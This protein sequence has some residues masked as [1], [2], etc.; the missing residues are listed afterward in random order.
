MANLQELYYD[1]R[2]TGSL[3]GVQRLKKAADD[4][5]LTATTNDVKRFL[6][7]Q[8][9]YTLF[10]P[11][12][13]KF[14]RRRVLFRDAADL[15]QADL[16]DMTQLGQHNTHRYFL[17]VINAFTKKA[18]IALLK[19]KTAKE[20]AEAFRKMYY[21]NNL[22]YRNLQTDM[23]GE[24]RS[25]FTATLNDLGVNQ[26]FA[27]S[28]KKAALIERCIKTIKTRLWRWMHKNNTYI[29]TEAI[30]DIVFSYNHSY[31]RSIG[32][33]PVEVTEDNEEEV[34]EKLFPD[35]D[36]TQRRYRFNPGD[37]VRVS[38]LKTLLEK[39]YTPTTSYPTY[40]VV[41]RSVEAD[42][43]TY[44]LRDALN[45]QL[46][47]AFYEEELTRF[48]IPPNFQW[49]VERTIKSRRKYGRVEHLIKWVDF[50]P[51]YNSWV[52]AQDLFPLNR[53]R[54]AVLP[55]LDETDSESE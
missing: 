45:E 11:M 40:T 34:R 2:S 53:R 23:G 21:D 51:R 15:A 50:P 52:Q 25:E 46:K 17:L 4:A 24:F 54:L 6:E 49:R 31:H 19:R 41:D 44:T 47:G 13:K 1:P 48:N 33:K 39:G 36:V 29:W 32:M 16:G 26:Y 42:R 22:L 10:K 7:T 5:G 20:C 37:N 18:Y 27:Y 28:D 14:T 35:D 12:R 30:K 3:G 8:D 55:G 43:N 9:A 38:R